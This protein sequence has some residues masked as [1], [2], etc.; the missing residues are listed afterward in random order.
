MSTSQRRT[1]RVYPPDG[2]G[3][4][5][6]RNPCNN[7]AVPQPFVHLN[8]SEAQLLAQAAFDPLLRFTNVA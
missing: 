3:I 2:L 5:V 7:N 8:N 4:K 6:L 1:H